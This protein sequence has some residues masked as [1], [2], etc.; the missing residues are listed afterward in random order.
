MQLG[1]FEILDELGRGGFGVVYN[2]RDKALNRLVAIQ[3]LHPNLVNDP[4]FL[5]RFK[6]EAQIAANLDHSNLVPVYD[7][8]E[9]KGRYYIVMGYMPRGSLKDLLKREGSLSKE[10]ALEI[11]EQI[12]AGLSYAHRKGV[13]HRDLKPGN[14]LFDKEDKARV[15]DMGFAKLLHSESSSSMSTSGGLVGTPT[16][17]APEIWLGK[18]ASA[19]TDVYSLACILIEMLTG[20]PFFD[21]ETTPEVMFR[22]FEPLQLPEGLAGE[23][24]LVIEQAL[25]KKPEK[26]F[27]SVAEFITRLQKAEEKP[28]PVPFPPVQS[29]PQ[30]Q[31]PPVQTARASSEIRSSRSHSAKPQT[32]ARKPARW[33]W[34]E[35]IVSLQNK[36]LV[37]IGLVLLIGLTLF[38]ILRLSDLPTVTTDK[39]ITRIRQQDGMEMVYVPEGDFEMG[40]DG[41]GGDEEPVRQVFLDGFWIDK[42]EVSN[43]Q[44]ALCVAAGAC[45]E[46]RLTISRT[47][48]GYYG[49]PEYDDF[50]VM[51]VSWNDA[52]VYCEWTGGE[53]P[54]EAQWEKAA[55]GS[56]GRTYPWGDG[57]ANCSRANFYSNVYC[58]GDTNA[59]GSYPD[60]ASPHGT[61]DMAGNLWEWV[62]DWYGEYDPNETKNPTGAASGET[63]VLRGGSWYYYFKSIRAFDRSNKNPASSNDNV[64]FRCSSRQ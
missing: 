16:Y 38:L 28:S 27:G 41:G 60:G 55:R 34:K 40:S 19:S 20:K 48:K 39:G 21:G 52:S 7:F 15:S 2:A 43:A 32:S 49:N 11:L 6:Q 24:K 5:A 29:R 30:H 51:Y 37:Y 23:W 22:H 45:S 8:G 42:Y 3:I 50:P 26:R 35:M 1:K 14:I 46:P 62:S 4:S 44:Y 59:V 17:M 54:T 13:I 53:L 12:G 18:G 31:I 58:V 10:R 36:P 9:S 63:K 61:L 47:R 64:G 33:D 25:E 56:D 57:E